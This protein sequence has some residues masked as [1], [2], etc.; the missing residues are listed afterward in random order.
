[1]ATPTKSRP[2]RIFGSVL[3][4]VQ[5]IGGGIT[6]V[7]GLEGN[8]DLATWAGLAVLISGALTLTLIPA[9]EG[10]VVPAVD[11]LAFRSADST[12]V[13]GPA[14]DDEQVDAGYEAEHSAG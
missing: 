5:L 2:V 13:S 12:I 11:V 1:M 8:A 6:G 3:A 14:A 7:A 9:L 10:K 4:A